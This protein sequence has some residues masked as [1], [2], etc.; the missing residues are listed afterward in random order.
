MQDGQGASFEA[1]IHNP[2]IGK[3]MGTLQHI[4]EEHNQ[5]MPVE[6]VGELTMIFSALLESMSKGEIKDCECTRVEAT[7]EELEE[8]A[9]RAMEENV[10]IHTKSK[11]IN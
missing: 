3:V 6:V 9:R 10:L 1:K 8:M 11:V 2:L 7:P 4:L 5:D